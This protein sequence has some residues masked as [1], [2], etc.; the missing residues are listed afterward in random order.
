M[1]D[2]KGFDL[3]ADGY[4][5]SVQLCEEDNEYPFAGYKD[6]LNTIYNIVHRKEKAKVLDIGF[7]TGVLTKKLYDDGYEIYGI[8][9]SER[10]LEIAK[11][12]MPLAKLVQYDFSRGLPKELENI[13]FN[14]IISTYAMHH[15]EDEDKIKFINKLEKYLSRDGRIIIGD[16][17]FETRE[18]LEQCKVKYEN[19][20]DDEEIYFVFDELKEFFPKEDISFTTI[21]H[22]A[23]II[24]LRKLP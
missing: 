17:A 13:Q 18:L 10:M 3:W 1:L 20:W 11:E 8:D 19:Y 7:G 23:G 9:F 24:Q 14:Y 12:K 15:L 6:V 4:D 21:S 5:K 2:N 22:C 16:I